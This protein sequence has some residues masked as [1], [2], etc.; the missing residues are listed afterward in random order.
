MSKHILLLVNNVILK[1]KSFKGVFVN[2]EGLLANKILARTYQN[3]TDEL[4][5]QRRHPGK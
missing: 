2:G 3:L 1:D 4:S 5:S